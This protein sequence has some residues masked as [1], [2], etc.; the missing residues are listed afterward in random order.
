M[1]KVF[2]GREARQQIK[3]VARDQKTRIKTERQEKID[4]GE[5][6]APIWH[7][8]F[9]LAEVNI[10]ANQ[11]LSQD[12]VDRWGWVPIFGDLLKSNHLKIESGAILLLGTTREGQEIPKEDRVKKAAT[13]FFKSKV[14]EL[15]AAVGLALLVAPEAALLGLAGKSTKAKKAAEIALKLKKA[16]EVAKNVEA[17]TKAIK[18]LSQGDVRRAA[19]EA[20][21][22]V[23]SGV[24]H[25]FTQT[26][27]WKEAG[28][29]KLGAH[30]IQK[31]PGL[32]EAVIAE[33]T[34]ADDLAAQKLQG[35]AKIIPTSNQPLAQAA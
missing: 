10:R 6:V 22:A 31:H 3:Q 33:S 14:A 7:H 16:E 1:P 17:G 34:E 4:R 32:V 19:I 24:A 2:R 15:K 25:R 35:F 11:E 18:S 21:P 23:L 9:D 27:R 30:I 12:W 29:V 26:G 13:A 28:T 8:W 20:T 5:P